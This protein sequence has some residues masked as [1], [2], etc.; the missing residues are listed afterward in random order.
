M[1]RSKTSECRDEVNAAAIRYGG[2]ELLNV[3]GRFDDSQ[4]VAQPLN[5]GSTDKDTSLQREI[6]LPS[7]LPCDGGDELVVRKRRFLADVHQHEAASTV[8][9]LGFAA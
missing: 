4:S 3:R 1:R 2:G 5:D 9:V 8:G 6:G 7:R